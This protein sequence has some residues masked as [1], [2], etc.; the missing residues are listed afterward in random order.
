VSSFTIFKQTWFEKRQ[1]PPSISVNTC[2]DGFDDACAL[3]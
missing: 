1:A 2:R 3:G